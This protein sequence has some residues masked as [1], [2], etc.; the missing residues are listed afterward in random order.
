[1]MTAILAN[2][3]RRNGKSKNGKEADKQ[4]YKKG[5]NWEV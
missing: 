4:N 1:M 2:F 3:L 5:N